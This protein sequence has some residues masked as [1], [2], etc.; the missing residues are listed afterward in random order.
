MRLQHT[1]VVRMLSY[2]NDKRTECQTMK[3]L[4]KEFFSSTTITKRKSFSL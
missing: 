4:C 2:A 3:Q 1:S